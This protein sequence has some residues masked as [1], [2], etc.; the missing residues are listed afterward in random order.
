MTTTT[1]IIP[2]LNEEKTIGKVVG[3][4]L[5]CVPEAKVVVCDNASS[6]R[7]RELALKAGAAVISEPRQGKGYALN[8]AL[9][10]L[11]SDL[12][13]I[14]DGDDTYY[15]EDAGKLL[16]PVSD[17]VCD[18]AVGVRLMALTDGSVN[19]LRFIGNKGICALFN[20]IHGGGFRDI[21]SGYRALNSSLVKK[22]KL[23]CGGFEV[24]SEITL[25][26]L[27]NNARVIEVPIPYKRRTR[28][29]TSNLNIFRDGWKIT[30]AIL[31]YSPVRRQRPK[32]GF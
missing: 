27:T 22:L 2:A 17:G 8:T 14:V 10:S 32:A 18:M 16:K 15:A 31:S 6:D 26:A 21:L 30:R 4:F 9:K 29:S 5:R 23:R 1:V 12:Y 19:I 7:T 20:T 3:D 11:E 25:K 28:G 24:E 13:I